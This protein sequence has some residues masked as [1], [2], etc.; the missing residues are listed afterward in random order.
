MG[1]TNTHS[2]PPFRRSAGNAGLV[3]FL[4]LTTSSTALFAE[5]IDVKKE[6]AELKSMIHAQNAQI[7]S[8]KAAVGE[9]RT[10]TR[11]N[12]EKIKV[13]AE[14]AYAPP[15]LPPGYTATGFN[16]IGGFDDKKLHFGGITITPGGFMAAES[17]YRTRATQSGIISNFASIPFG[18]TSLAHTSEFKASA[19][20]SRFAMLAEGAITPSI[21]GAGYV[22][23]D[24]LGAG[25]TS[26]LNQTN[27]YVPR[28]RNLYTTFDFNDSGFHVLAGQN[29]SLMTLNSK[30]IT[31]R[32]EVGPPTIDN[33]PMPGYVYTRVPQL[34]ITKDFDKR[35]WVSLSAEA[36]QTSFA[37]GCNA[38]VANTGAAIAATALPVGTGNVTCVAQ[39]TGGGFAQAGETNQFSLNHVPDVIG[40]IAYEARIADRDVHIEGEGMY[41]DFYDRVN[42]G[43]LLATGYSG[44][45]ANQDTT[46]Y[47]F[48]GG[49]VAAVIP[50]KLDFEANGLV[51]RGIGR[52]S[53]SPLGDATIDNN[54]SIR[55]LYGQ[56][57]NGGFVLHATPT[58]D[59][60][61]SAG[62]DQLTAS[63]QSNGAGGY[64]GYGAPN[65]NDTGCNIEGS[66][67]T[68]CAGNTHRVW[69]LTGGVWDKIYQGKFGF[70]RAGL[71]YSYTQ[72]E[73]YASSNGPG[74]ASVTPKTEDHMLL[75]SLRYYPF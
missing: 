24:F 22:E 4:L 33:Q 16:P 53:G 60:Y 28:V 50:G 9:Q 44:G 42:Y 2:K 68:T 29:W 15:A 8:L 58:L 17:V 14:R 74:G 69:Q 5:D 61:A 43:T 12:K 30:G 73:L 62:M 49:I 64:T 25:T 27:S 57:V 37:N 18:Q 7:T 59:F 23:I 51:G 48:G 72:R 13:V 6:I 26:N 10:E 40:K 67:A 1:S 66:A 75:T 21:L 38:T 3:A 39:G 70:F 20:Q 19:Q 71:Q 56:S 41:R 36:S 11:H 52:Y 65:A 35:L 45:S 32:N 46:G 63:Y 31:P 47:G 55:P 34:R 54:G